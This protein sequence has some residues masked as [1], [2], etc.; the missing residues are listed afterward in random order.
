VR[1]SC[2]FRR[3]KSRELHLDLNTRDGTNIDAAQLEGTFN[4]LGFDT[5]VYHNQTAFQILNIVENGKRFN[6]IILFGNY[7]FTSLVV[8]K[9]HSQ[10]DCFIFVM[11][12]HGDDR[13]IIY[14]SDQAFSITALTEPFK[15]SANT[16]LGKPKIFIF[17]VRSD[18]FLVDDFIR[19]LG[20]SG[21]KS[22]DIASKITHER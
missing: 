12:S 4:E 17:Q 14:G 21:S 16:L 22:H 15:R 7:L 1:I 11:L 20:M 6:R 13:D 5:Y 10:N 18:R 8:K 2:F 19:V 9:D 3:T